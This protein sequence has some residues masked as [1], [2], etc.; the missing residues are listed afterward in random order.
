MKSI[1][2]RTIFSPFSRVASV[3]SPK[4]PLGE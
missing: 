4:M 3:A 2:A 1:C